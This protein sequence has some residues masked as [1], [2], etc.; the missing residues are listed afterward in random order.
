MALAS[1]VKL[2]VCNVAPGAAVNW[3]VAVFMSRGVDTPS[4]TTWSPPL[5]C[6]TTMLLMGGA[7]ATIFVLSTGAGAGVISRAPSYKPR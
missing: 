6:V 5:I 4:I 2:V 1:T 7:E 3:N